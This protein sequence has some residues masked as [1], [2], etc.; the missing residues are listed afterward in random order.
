MTSN[1][2]NRVT[3]TMHESKETNGLDQPLDKD[4]NAYTHSGHVESIANWCN[5]HLR[6]TL[7]TTFAT[8]IVPTNNYKPDAQRNHKQIHHTWMRYFQTTHISQKK[9]IARKPFHIEMLFL[10]LMVIV[11]V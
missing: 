2:I 5:H 8:H 11:I 9:Q 3:K 7:D 1:A 6:I 10:V 4:S